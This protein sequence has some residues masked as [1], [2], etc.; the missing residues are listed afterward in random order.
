METFSSTL[1]VCRKENDVMLKNS[2]RLNPRKNIS[3][4]TLF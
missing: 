1:A 2:V 3:N 4:D